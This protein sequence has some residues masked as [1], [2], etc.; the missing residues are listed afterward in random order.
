MRQRGSGVVRLVWRPDGIFRAV[1]QAA[2]VLGEFRGKELNRTKFI[3]AWQLMKRGKK[4][5]KLHGGSL[6][7]SKQGFKRFDSLEIQNLRDF[8]YSIRS[9]RPAL[10]VLAME[11]IA[12]GL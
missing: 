10:A 3:G 2:F 9:E 8:D 11:Q 5:G 7:V 6:A 1:Q 4:L 12:G